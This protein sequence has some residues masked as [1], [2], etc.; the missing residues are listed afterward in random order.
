M[1]KSISREYGVSPGSKYSEWFKVQVVREFETGLYTLAHLERKYGIPGHSTIPRW[2][3]K[4]GSV[5]Y[6]RYQSV[7]RPMKDKDQQRIKELETALAKKEAELDA[8]KKFIS[9]AE[10]ELQIKIVKKSGTKQSKK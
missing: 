8:Y 1:S 10:R 2:L 5:S 6:V 9:I 4:Y 3:R 7:G